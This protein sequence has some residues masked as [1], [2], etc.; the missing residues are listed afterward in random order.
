MYR[1]LLK[2]YVDHAKQLELNKKNPKKE[3]WCNFLCQKYVP[4]AEFYTKQGRQNMCIKCSNKHTTV[5]NYIKQG[6]ITREQFKNNPNIIEECVKHHVTDKNL[7]CV[8]CKEIKNM[9][10]FDKN[11][12]VCKKCRVKQ[13]KDRIL[14]RMDDDIKEIEN[15]KN[16][17]TTLKQ[18]VK[19]LPVH[20]IFTIMKHYG[21]TRNKNDKKDDAVFKVIQHFRHLQ[22]PNQCLGNCGFSLPEEFSF[23]KECKNNDRKIS[24]EEKNHMFKDNL[25]IFMENMYELTE[26]DMYKHNTFCIN[27]IAEYLGITLFKTKVKGNMK[28]KMV[29]AINE[30]L[31]SKKDKETT[32]EEQKIPELELN[33]IVIMCREDGYINATKL[34]KAGGKVFSKWYR[35]DSTKKLINT[36]FLKIGIPPLKL[37]ESKKG[38][39][40][41]GSWIHPLIANNL[42]QWL[43]IDFSLKVSQWIEEWKCIKKENIDKYNDSLI[44]IVPDKDINQAERKIQIKLQKELG[45]DIE[46][47]TDFGFID[48]LTNTEIIEIKSGNLWKHGL[49]QLCVYGEFYKDHI[50][51]LHLFDFEY[52]EK[53]NKLCEKY[54]IKVSYENIV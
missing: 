47:E 38:G 29:K 27:A 46:V 43:S 52:N 42:A 50:K 16:N 24:V 31:K 22:D 36:L 25:P 33:G 48:L 4:L 21:L 1:Q 30:V 32:P 11:R 40:K 8:T 13:S 18:F 20:E 10:F 12:N 5:E 15:L 35:L 49:G 34:C 6:R 28:E 9:R 41:S 23:C 19:S 3:K 2:T 44:N 39:N 7:E 51:R 26:E 17:E 54:N 53:I 45:G 37:I 14:K